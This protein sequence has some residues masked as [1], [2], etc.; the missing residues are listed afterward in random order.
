[1]KIDT[2]NSRVK[3][4]V[5]KLFF[6]TVEG[7]LPEVKG[8]V[9]SEGNN[10][11]SFKV[12]LPIANIDTKNKKRDEHLLQDDFFNVEKYPEITF[13]STEIKQENNQCVA[14]GNLSIAGTTKQ[15]KFP[16][17][18]SNGKITGELIVNRLDYKVGKVPTFVVAKNIAVNFDCSVK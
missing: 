11:S 3:F 7:I 12:S 18:H 6:L 4:K 16:F 15:M 8:T 9:E 2:T 13:V 10:I 1:M 17:K 5:K 14:I